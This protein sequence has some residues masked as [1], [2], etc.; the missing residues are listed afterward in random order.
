SAS[1][2]RCARRTT[3]DVMIKIN[4]IGQRKARG[5]RALGGGGRP[6]VL[7]VALGA[8]ALVAV[9][10]FA[11][12]LPLAGEVDDLEK[13]NKELQEENA[14]L[15]RRTK[16]SRALREAFESEL[17]RQN[18][19]QRLVDTR[20]TPAWLMN[21]LSNILTPGKQPQLTPEM[22]AE[23]RNNPNRPWQDGWDPKHVWISEFVEKDG[24]FVMKGGAQSKGDVIELGLRL[25]DR[26]STR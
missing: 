8:L 26:K 23:L 5:R 16:N 6:V 14:A 9:G 2:S 3:S 13:A 19:T 25:R 12:H 20:V 15:E 18:A 17:A 24:A 7:L 1:G 11:V 21:E 10:L 22:Q 4:L